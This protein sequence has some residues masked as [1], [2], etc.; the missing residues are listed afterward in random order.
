LGPVERVQA[1]AGEVIMNSVC[2]IGSGHVG[3]VTGACL[4]ELGNTV[5]CVDNNARKIE[6]LKEGKIPF[7][8]PGLEELVHRNANN[9][10]LSFTTDIE[11]GIKASEIIFISVG[12]PSMSDGT[13]DMT[14]FEAVIKKISQT[15]DN[16][17]VVVEKSTVP[18]K[19]GEW[20]SKILNSNQGVGF[21]IVCNPEFLREGSALSDFMHPDRIIIGTASERAIKIMTELYEPLNAPI[22][23]NDI[24]TAELIKHASNCFLALKISFINAVAIIC[25]KVGA[26]VVKVAEGMGHDRRIG[27][28]FLNAGVGYGGSCFPKDLATFIKIADDAGYDFKLLKDVRGINDFQQQ[29]VIDKARCQ[30]HGLTEKIIGILGISF[31]PHTDDIRE[32][33]A[34]NIIRKLQEAGAI[35]K[36]YDPQAMR[37]AMEVLT[38]VE[39]CQNPYEAAT[40]CDVLIII[41]E[42]DEFKEIDL[43]RLKLLMRQPIIIDGRNIYEPQEMKK[44]GFTYFGTGR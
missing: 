4:A 10:R 21:D 42:W 35:V 27:H 32:A 29:Q 39:Y 34:I 3:L 22:I 14:F 18:V 43:K 17:K 30:L 36:V 41:T 8:E 31:K 15:I 37:K 16:Y 23:I 33:P 26:D 44:L 24:E 19:T 40:G 1:L 13:A 9:G 2:I 12:T 5:I 28:A 6:G 11:E 25:E 7:Y 38:D 20:I